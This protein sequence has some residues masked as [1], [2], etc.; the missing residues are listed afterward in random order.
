M[1]IGLLCSLH[2]QT[3][4]NSSPEHNSIQ[5]TE[6][7]FDNYVYG[8]FNAVLWSPDNG[9][10]YT[11]Y[12]NKVS[13]IFKYKLKVLEIFMSNI[14]WKNND[15]IQNQN[16][17]SVPTKQFF[18]NYANRKIEK[19]IPKRIPREIIKTLTNNNV[20][21]QSTTFSRV[22]SISTKEIKNQSD[23]NYYL[24]TYSISTVNTSRS[25][26]T[27]TPLNISIDTSV[28]FSSINSTPMTSNDTPLISSIAVNDIQ[29]F[30]NNITN[31]DKIK[32][33]SDVLLDKRKFLFFLIK[34]YYFNYY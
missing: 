30:Q 19:N 33:F 29:T 17:S 7:S 11:R 9:Y 24:T 14:N 28:I 20:I 23:L 25:T 32:I 2:G 15:Y 4:G 3:N 6:N 8:R 1:F 13:D 16:A 31:R 21:Q 5:N 10:H 34:Y 12:W 26:S 18:T 27:L 22:P